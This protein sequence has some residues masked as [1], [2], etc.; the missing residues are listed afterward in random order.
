MSHHVAHVGT[1]RR[2]LR[3]EALLEV[4]LGFVE[5]QSLGYLLAVTPYLGFLFFSRPAAHARVVG[6]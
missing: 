3:M 5:N 4:D 1:P 2:D 6:S